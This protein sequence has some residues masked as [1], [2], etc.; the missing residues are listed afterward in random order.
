VKISAHFLSDHAIK[1]DIFF[2]FYTYI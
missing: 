2:K 1:C